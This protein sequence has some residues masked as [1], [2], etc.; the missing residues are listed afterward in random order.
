MSAFAMEAGNANFGAGAV[1]S[2]RRFLYRLAAAVAIVVLVVILLVLLV[3]MAVIGVVYL[4][5]RSVFS[6]FSGGARQ[7][8]VEAPAH[9][10]IPEED[11]EG[12]ENV[13]VR[14]VEHE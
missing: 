9:Q 2:V 8:E 12:R 5:V 14:R 6:G 4:M 10:P 11:G 7:A 13:R 1:E 3:P